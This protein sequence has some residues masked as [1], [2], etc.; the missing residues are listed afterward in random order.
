MYVDVYDKNQHQPIFLSK[1]ILVALKI[2]QIWRVHKWIQ[3]CRKVG[4]FYWIDAN[5]MQDF[6]CWG[7]FEWTQ[8]HLESVQWIQTRPN[9]FRVSTPKLELIP[10]FSEF[11]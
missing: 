4:V 5:L 10:E 11:F 1:D 6:T 3:K 8:L 7:T 9:V 2:P